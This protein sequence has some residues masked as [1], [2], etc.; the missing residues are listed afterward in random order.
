M[1]EV[2]VDGV[3][4]SKGEGTGKW[5]GSGNEGPLK[6]RW[7]GPHGTCFMGYEDSGPGLFV[8]HWALLRLTGFTPEHV[9]NEHWR[10]ILNTI[11]FLKKEIINWVSD[12]NFQMY[13]RDFFYRLIKFLLCID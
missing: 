13:K 8:D 7:F 10:L 4:A 11:F 6:G 5:R 2:V 9:G 12:I 3:V 1:S